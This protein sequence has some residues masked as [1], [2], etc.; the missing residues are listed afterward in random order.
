MKK[1]EKLNDNITMLI[2]DLEKIQPQIKNVN[3]MLNDFRQIYSILCNEPNAVSAATIA[4][5]IAQK[6]VVPHDG[7]SDK[8]WDEIEKKE[9]AF[10]R[11]NYERSL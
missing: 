5:D 7:N 1:I 2:R 10:H 9:D 3:R 11:S 4:A 6:W 8:M